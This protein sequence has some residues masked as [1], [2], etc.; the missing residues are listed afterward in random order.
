[1]KK[2]RIIRISSDGTP[3]ETR[4][5]MDEGQD[6]DR[7]VEARWNL[8][9]GQLSEVELTI[10]GSAAQVEGI[11]QHVWLKCPICSGEVSHECDQSPDLRGRDG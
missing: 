5:S 8:R 1:M 11:L 4:I 2:N 6:L 7:V 10:W 9:V 3:N